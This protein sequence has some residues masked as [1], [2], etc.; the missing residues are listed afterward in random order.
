MHIVAVPGSLDQ[1][2]RFLSSCVMCHQ[3]Y[4]SANGMSTAV[5]ILSG[6]V[7]YIGHQSTW[8]VKFKLIHVSDF[9]RFK[10][11]YFR[12]KGLISTK[13]V[14]LISATR[15]LSKEIKLFSG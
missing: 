1:F 7:T 4:F 6:H 10:H 5:S 15:S 9:C 13:P 14:S 2:I 12:Y 11:R 3:R 8:L